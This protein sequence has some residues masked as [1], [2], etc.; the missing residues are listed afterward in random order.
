M[1]VQQEKL[2]NKPDVDPNRD[3]QH[4]HRAATFGDEQSETARGDRIPIEIGL[5]TVANG[6]SVS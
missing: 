6:P 5:R 1:S 2:L 4:A 3:Q